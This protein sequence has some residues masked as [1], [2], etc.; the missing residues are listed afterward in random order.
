MTEQTTT[1]T[2]PEV[3]PTRAKIVTWALAVP[4]SMALGLSA[5]TSYR[6]A[7]ERLD[8]TDLAERLALCAT[9]EAAIIALTL[10]SWGARSKASAWLAYGFV[11]VQAV[12]AFAVS[13][14][15]G[16]I[17]RVAAGPVLLALMLHKLLG[18]E[19]KFSGEKSQG[20]LA[21]AGREIRERLT[22]RLGIGQRGADSAAIARSRAA[23]RAVALASKRSLGKRA[24][25]RLAVAIDAAQ[26]G[27]NE[28]D[29]A[30]AEASIVARIVRRKSVAALHG[31]DARHAWLASAAA[32]DAATDAA[33][34]ADTDGQ[35]G[36]QDSDIKRPRKRSSVGQ[37]AATKTAKFAAKHPNMPV[38]ELAKKLGLSERTVR[39]HLATPQ[40]GAVAIPAQPPASGLPVVTHANGATV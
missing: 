40:P 36:G 37:D 38:P 9:V 12:P 7:A 34:T 23:D 35:N 17:F 33:S 39:R 19:M 1:E 14:G 31:L 24:A 25:V 29:A 4:A 11:A 27:L 8:I 22:A 20:L 30:A 5:S 15:L 32:T 13:G 6:F 16:G 18:L 28:T 2:T 26:H 10:H 3:N 21:S